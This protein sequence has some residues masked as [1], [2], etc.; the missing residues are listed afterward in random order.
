MNDG[1]GIVNVVIRSECD[2]V[3]SACFREWR[4]GLAASWCIER[5]D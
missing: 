1:G 3:K 2:V 5:K 4:K